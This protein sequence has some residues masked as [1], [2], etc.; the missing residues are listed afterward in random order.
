MTKLLL[1]NDKTY[2][3]NVNEIGDIVGVFDDDHVFSDTEKTVFDIIKVTETKTV[4]DI[5]I[6]ETKRLTRAGTIE[7]TD[8]EPERKEVWKD[9]DGKFKDIVIDPKYLLRYASDTKEIK[10]SYSQY[11]ENL[12]VQVITKVI[13]DTK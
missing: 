8:E 9:I 6:P 5:K 11:P 7:W 12:T 4:I 13:L 3:E 2:K 10:E 1:I